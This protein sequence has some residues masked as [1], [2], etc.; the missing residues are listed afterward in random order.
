MKKNV[1]ES[2]HWFGSRFQKVLDAQ[3]QFI[4]WQCCLLILSQE[5]VRRV[6]KG[7]QKWILKEEPIENAQDTLNQP[8]AECWKPIAEKCGTMADASPASGCWAIAIA[9]RG[10]KWQPAAAPM[11]SANSVP[12]LAIQHQPLAAK[13]TK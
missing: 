13:A 4:G 11:L 6:K 2:Q 10:S 12:R 8:V 5:D 1:Q 7:M 9:E 3:Y